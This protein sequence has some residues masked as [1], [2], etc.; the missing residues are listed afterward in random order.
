MKKTLKKNVFIITL[1]VVVAVLFSLKSIYA[2]PEIEEV[3]SASDVNNE[4]ETLENL[5]QKFTDVP[6][7]S[8]YA[9]SVNVV[10]EKGIMSGISESEFV[11]DGPVTR[12]MFTTILYRLAGEPEADNILVFDDI[13][14]DKYYYNAV[15]WAYTCGIIDGYTDYK[16]A[17]DEPITREQMVSILYRFIRFDEYG[18]DIYDHLKISEFSDFDSISEYAVNHVEW[19]YENGLIRGINGKF[20]PENNVT[21]AE[22]AII[23]ERLVTSVMIVE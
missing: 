11:P 17:P 9:Q 7:Y 15:K 10:T 18:V 5:E 21:R 20:E 16:F 4:Y 6:V 23:L 8:W 1:I 14:E 2:T 13:D 19:A 12:A 22:M 3:I